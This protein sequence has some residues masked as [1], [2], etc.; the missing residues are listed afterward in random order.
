MTVRPTKNK[1]RKV[2]LALDEK[3]FSFAHLKLIGVGFTAGIFPMV[4]MKVGGEIAFIPWPLILM[5]PVMF[6]LGILA[7]VTF[8]LLVEQTY[9]LI[10]CKVKKDCSEK[11]SDEDC[12]HGSG[13][14]GV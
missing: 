7:L 13:E 11:D 5:A 12:T 9:I 14:N 4:L 8:L 1:K 2:K 10:R 3:D 6:I